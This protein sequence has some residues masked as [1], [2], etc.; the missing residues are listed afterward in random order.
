M[1]QIKAC[2][3]CFAIS[4]SGTEILSPDQVASVN[5]TDEDDQGISLIN[6][7]NSFDINH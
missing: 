5:Q 3:I 2:T 1:S 4:Y 6:I 7:T